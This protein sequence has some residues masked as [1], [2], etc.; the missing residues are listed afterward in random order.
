MRVHDEATVAAMATFRVLAGG[1]H[2][3]GRWRAMVRLIC[4][5]MIFIFSPKLFSRSIDIGEACENRI[6]HMRLHWPHAKIDFYINLGAGRPPT[7][8]RK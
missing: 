6:L 5:F 1:G 3:F 2:G 8:M 7:L 4:C